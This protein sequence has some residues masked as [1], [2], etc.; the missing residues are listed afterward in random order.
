MRDRMKHT[1]RRIGGD[2]L[3][4]YCT[5]CQHTWGA[6]GHTLPSVRVI[7]GLST[8]CE[9]VPQSNEATIWIVMIQVTLKQLELA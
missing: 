3:R 4:L 6:I 7:A 8:D 2:A 9:Q 5:P 1:R